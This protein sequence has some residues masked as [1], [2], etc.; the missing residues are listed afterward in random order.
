M[1]SRTLIAAVTALALMPAMAFAAPAPAAEKA[2]LTVS[3]P[4]KVEKVTLVKHHHHALKK[5]MAHP[6]TKAKAT[7]NKV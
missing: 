6:H 7:A 3:K 4:M 1:T 2:P 5:A